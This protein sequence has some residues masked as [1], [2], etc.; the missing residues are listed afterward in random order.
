MTTLLTAE[1]EKLLLQSVLLLFAQGPHSVYC[2]AGFCWF[3]PFLQ[4]GECQRCKNA[5]GSLT[6]S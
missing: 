5:A 4:A 2:Q 6:A 3:L 1:K